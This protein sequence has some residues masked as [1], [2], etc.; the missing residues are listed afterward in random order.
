MKDI[1]PDTFKQTETVYH[2][3]IYSLIR[4]V[5]ISVIAQPPQLE[6][7]IHTRGHGHRGLICNALC[8]WSKVQADGRLCVGLVDAGVE[9]E[10][11]K[12]M[13]NQ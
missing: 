3:R 12:K 1:T 10:S 4:T 2:S 13:K 9:F 8:D 6:L 11:A 7:A 5:Y